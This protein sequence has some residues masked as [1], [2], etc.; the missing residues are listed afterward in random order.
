MRA[1][2]PRCSSPA[3]S[4][5]ATRAAPTTPNPGGTT[6]TVARTTTVPLPAAPD[7]TVRVDG[8]KRRPDRPTSPSATPPQSGSE[9][10]CIRAVGRPGLRRP[11]RRARRRRSRCRA[12]PPTPRSLACKRRG[13]D[14]SEPLQ[15]AADAEVLATKNEADVG[16]DCITVQQARDIFRAGSPYNSWSQLG[17]FDL[18]IT[19][20]GREDGSPN[21]TF[22]GQVVLGVARPVAG[23]RARRLRRPHDRQ[24]RARG[25]HRHR[26]RAGAPR[27]RSPT[28]ASSWR[29]ALA[30]ERQRE[31]RRGRRRAPIARCCARS[32][33]RTAP[34]SA[35]ARRCRTA[36]AAR[37][38]AR[39]R[40]RDERA[41]RIA[42]AKVNARYDK[43]IRDRLRRY[44][45]RRASPR[46]RR[47]ASSAGSASPTTS[48]SRT[49]CARW[50]STT[51][52]R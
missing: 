23:R 25:G 3:A 26:A 12:C 46:R 19:A 20:T 36:E 29:R 13:V 32:P 4:T 44:R 52:C 48:S 37:I 33:R 47:P 28:T 30:K 14:L 21:F 22:F 24:G 17:F 2:P 10:A 39:N 15:I 7:D 8:L 35:A 43:E 40:A 27:R 34:A 45:A 6:A 9:V 41:K 5:P 50:R 11:V 18:P 38:V 51:A 42:R 1:W 16:G 31:H 49:S